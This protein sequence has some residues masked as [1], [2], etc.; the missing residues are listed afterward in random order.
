MVWG[1]LQ[2]HQVAGSIHISAKSGRFDL[3][4]TQL[5]DSEILSLYNSSHIIH[6]YCYYY[7]FNHSFTFGDPIPGITNPL[8]NKQTFIQNCT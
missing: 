7:N 5:Y 4:G 2:V 3:N 1:A 6:Q 8:Q